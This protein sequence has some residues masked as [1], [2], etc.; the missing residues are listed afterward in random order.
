MHE[1]SIMR[2]ALD[3]AFAAATGA[4]ARRILTIKLRIGALSGVVP[5]ALAFAFEGLKTD[6]MAAEA[7]LQ[8]VEVPVACWCAVCGR[9]FEAEGAYYECPDCGQPS[10]DI[11]RG[12]EMDLMAV[13]V[14]QDDEPN[15]S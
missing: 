2:S 12:R 1:V 5:E 13:E 14:F 10:I 7:T 3:A 6:T 4:G 11:R 8:V 9:E 15:E